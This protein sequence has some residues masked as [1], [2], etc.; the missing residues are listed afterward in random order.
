MQTI[1]TKDQVRTLALSVKKTYQDFNER[2]GKLKK[3]QDSVI[4]SFL[5][6]L[7]K[8]KIDEIKGHIS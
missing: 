5:S 4:D 2:L 8:K 1:P 7:Q 6:A 3:E